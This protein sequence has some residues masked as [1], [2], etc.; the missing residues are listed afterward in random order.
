MGLDE[1]TAAGCRNGK[2]GMMKKRKFTLIELLVVIAIIAI[3]AAILLPALQSARTRA[4]TTSCINNLK[5]LGMIGQTY[6]NDHRNFW[7][8]GKANDTNYIMC[9]SRGKYLSEI[10]KDLTN[11][12]WT[13]RVASFASC[14]AAGLNPKVPLNDLAYWPQTYGT[15]Y[16]HNTNDSACKGAGYYPNKA[17][18]HGM[19]K[20]KWIA[21]GAV[22]G[23]VQQE[24]LGL[25]QRVMLGD[26]AF[27]YAGRMT[28]TARGYVGRAE[29]SASPNGAPYFIHGGRTNVATF[30]GNAVTV[31]VDDHWYNY[32]YADF[33]HATL[34]IFVVPKRYFLDTGDIYN[35]ARE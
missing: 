5:Q 34:P 33:G 25:A 10:Y 28:Q 24:N 21:G 16:V 13:K 32:V 15:Q 1:Q 26:I 30:A 9:L 17:Y 20:Y 11:N 2:G 31:D 4:Q 18:Q 6:M 7:P 12:A 8:A 27:L 22:G 14:P 19:V 23:T 29:A 3:L 35:E